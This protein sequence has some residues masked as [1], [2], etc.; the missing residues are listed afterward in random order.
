MTV[1]VA[2]FVVV[3]MKAVEGWEADESFYS[4]PFC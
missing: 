4:H 1:V 3:E 2:G